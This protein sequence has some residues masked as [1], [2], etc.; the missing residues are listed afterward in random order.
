MSD[1]DSFIDEVS[2]EVR[3]DRL[4]GLFRRYGWIPI[5]AVVLIVGGAAY[6]EWNKVQTRTAAEERGN[7]ILAA[8]DAAEPGDRVSALEEISAAS[9][10]QAIVAMLTAAEA[11]AADDP[12]AARSVLQEIEADA[13][14]PDLY[15]QMATLKRVMLSAA[16]TAP[17]ERIAALEPLTAAGAP[18]RVLAEEQIA[19]AEM[20]SGAMDAALTRLRALQEDIEASA[21]LRQRAAQLIMALGGVPDA[22]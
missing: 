9:R 8:L 21:G 16:D 5:L 2:E 6:N 4:Y 14:V 19:L 10:A 3:R 11:L 7:E 12:D 13:D 17:E 20:E 15:R 22:T 18:F 1:S